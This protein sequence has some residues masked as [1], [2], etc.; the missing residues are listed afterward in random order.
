MP[1]GT[2]IIQENGD[3][4]AGRNTGRGTKYGTRDTGRGTKFGTRDAGHGTKFGTRDMGQNLGHGKGIE[5]SY[6]YFY[7]YVYICKEIFTLCLNGHCFSPSC[8]S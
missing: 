7:K 8:H 4:D 1:G 3:R 6:E 2:V 5:Q